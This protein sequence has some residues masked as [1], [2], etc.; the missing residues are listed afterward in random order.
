MNRLLILLFLLGPLYCFA[1]QIQLDKDT[2]W[3]VFIEKPETV[4]KDTPLCIILPPGPGTK[5]MTEYA[6]DML[7]RPLALQGW[8]VAV[9]VSPDGKSFFGWT[10]EVKKLIEVLKKRK[11]I[12]QGK[13]LIGGISNGGISSIQIASEFPELFCGVIGV[14]GIAAGKPKLDNLK[15][16]P[17]FIR[18]GEKDE[19]KWEPG[20]RITVKQLKKAGALLDAELIKNGKHTF[21][22]P[23]KELDAW[24]QRYIYIQVSYSKWITGDD[25]EI[26]GV[27][28]RLEKDTALIMNRKGEEIR[29]PVLKQTELKQKQLEKFRAER[30]EQP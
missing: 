2:T 14:P 11:N 21:P 9:P 22:I 6:R 7:A 29:I 28:V 1:E 15:G 24:M 30:E 5:H 25:R 27:F 4:R 20:Y 26:E 17:V 16:M 12:H 13:V 23:I 8:Y 19:L 18:V 10:T 3:E